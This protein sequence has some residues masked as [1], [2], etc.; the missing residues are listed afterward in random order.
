MAG[1]FGAIV[2]IDLAVVA[3]KTG[4]AGTGIGVD[5]VFA[6][7]AIEAGV[8]GAVVDIRLAVIAAIARRTFACVAIE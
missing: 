5:A 4:C 8:V 6:A 3:R 2:D 7:T 1:V